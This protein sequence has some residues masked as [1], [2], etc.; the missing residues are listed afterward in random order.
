ALKPGAPSRRGEAA[1]LRPELEKRFDAVVDLPEEASIDGGDVLVTD[2]E[3]LVGL[4]ARTNAAGI[5][6]LAEALAPHG[7]RVRQAGTPAG[8][9]HLKS[10]CATLGE[11]AVLATQRLAA[12]GCFSGY[13]VIETAE[14]EEAAAN[15]IRGNDLGL[16]GAGVP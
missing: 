14:G 5:A 2:A 13:R 15:A 12:A 1:V 7:Y 11:D 9:L 3:V 10:D 8:V 4:S 16:L 6:A